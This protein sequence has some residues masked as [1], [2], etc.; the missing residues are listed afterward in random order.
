MAATKHRKPAIKLART[1]H[2]RLTLLADGFA[3]R[4]PAVADA[5]L[6]ELDRAG[7]VDDKRLAADTI[8][9]GS[10]LTYATS[11]GEERTVTLVYPAD[12]DIS[13][14]KISILTPIGAALIG[15]S[16]GQS[17]DWEARD[18]K[19]HRLNIEKVWPPEGQ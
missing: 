13:A 18:G 19:T 10:R 3:D 14:G 6:A 11:D 9:M 1:D 15:L 7:V 5:L 17:I 12:A 16:T 4:N 8:R 2:E